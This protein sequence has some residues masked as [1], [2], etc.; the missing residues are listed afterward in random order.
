M[1]VG[2]LDG[3]WERAGRLDDGGTAG[4]VDRIS[5]SSY[6]FLV[7]DDSSKWWWWYSSEYI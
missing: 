3:G 5:S 1:R 6:R 7:R 4:W 2:R